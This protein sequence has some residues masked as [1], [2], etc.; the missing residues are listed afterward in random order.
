MNLMK[1]LPTR[2]RESCVDGGGGRPSVPAFFRDQP[3]DEAVLV[4]S[5]PQLGKKIRCPRSLMAWI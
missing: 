1:E 3:V 4:E 5:I 2:R